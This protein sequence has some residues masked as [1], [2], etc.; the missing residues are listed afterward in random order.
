MDGSAALDSL[1]ADGFTLDMT[2]A[3]PSATT[4]HFMAMGSAATSVSV[5]PAARTAV[6]A[7]VAPTVVHGS[8]A[9]SPSELTAVAASEDPVVVL[10]STPIAPSESTVV[11]AKVDPTVL[12]GSTVA[13]P[14]AGTAVGVVAAPTVLAG[15]ISV[16]PDVIT[17]VAASVAPSVVH[18]SLALSPSSLT[19]VAAQAAPT[20]VLGSTSKTP[21]VVTAVAAS[22]GPTVDTGDII[23]WVDSD[24]ADDSG[25]G[26][27]GDPYKYLD[28]HV[29][30]LGAG[31]TVYIVG[32]EGSPRIYDEG[33]IN[34]TNSNGA[35]GQPITIM[36]APGT[37]VTWQKDAGDDYIFDIH[38]GADYI[39]INGFGLDAEESRGCVRM[40][41]DHG[42]LIYCDLDDASW[43][44]MVAVGG[45]DNE[46]GWCDFLNNYYGDS[47]DAHAISSSGGI[48]EL[49]VHHCTA[50]GI[51]GDF[52]QIGNYEVYHGQDHVIEWNTAWVTL[53]Q[54]ECCEGAVDMKEGNGI[55]RYNTFYNYHGT[56][57]S[58]GGSGSNGEVIFL[59]TTD[60]NHWYVYGNVIYGSTCALWVASGATCDFYWN[61]VYNMNATDANSVRS[62]AVYIGDASTEC[63]VWNNVFHNLGQGSITVDGATA[64]IR[65][66]IFN[67]CGVYTESDTPTVTID[68]NCWYNCTS[69]ESGTG[70]VTS[71]P[72]FADEAGDDYRLSSSS[73]CLLAG[74]DVGLAYSGSAPDMGAYDAAVP[75]AVTAVAA[76]LDP[77]IPIATSARTAVAVSVAPTVVLGSISNTPSA[78]TAVGVSTGPDLDL[79]S[80]TASPSELTA[81]GVSV[82]P[83]VVL[84][85]S[86][87]SPDAV[88]AVAASEDPSIAIGG[89]VTVSPDAVTAVGASTIGSAVQGNLSLTIAARSMIALDYGPA[90]RVNIGPQSITVTPE[91]AIAVAGKKD[92]Y[93]LYNGN[94]ILKIADP[95]SGH[96]AIAVADDI[97]R[98]KWW[99]NETTLCDNWFTVV[100]VINPRTEGGAVDAPYYEYVVN[101]ESG[102]AGYFGEGTAVVNYGQSGAGYVKLTSDDGAAGE[103][104]YID[105]ATHAGSPWSAITTHVRVGQLDGLGVISGS[106]WGLAA[107]TDLS[108]ADEPRVVVSDQQ[109]LLYKVDMTLCEGSITITGG[110]GIA[111]LS[112]A[113]A[114][115]VEDD[116]DGVPDGS[117]YKRVTAN[118]KTG[119]G[120]A[121]SGLDSN[122]NLVTS[123]V[124][125]TNAPV[126]GGAGLYIGADYMGYYD[127]SVWK[128][129]I[130]SNGDFQFRGN[131][132][133]TYIQ[134]DASENKLQGVGSGTEMWYADATDGKLKAGGGSIVLDNVGI[135]LANKA[136]GAS[137][138]LLRWEDNDGDVVA[139]DYGYDDSGSSDYYRGVE[140]RTDLMD[141][142][143]TGIAAFAVRR[144]AAFAFYQIGI[145]S[146]YNT[147][148]DRGI[149]EL[150]NAVDTDTVDDVVKVTNAAGT[151]QWQAD[152]TGD[153]RIAGGLH[154]GSTGTNPPADSITADGYIRASSGV[155][156]GQTG[157]PDTLMLINGTNGGAFYAEGTFTG[158]WVTIGGNSEVDGL[159]MM[160][161]LYVQ[162]VGHVPGTALVTLTMAGA[163]VDV[164][165][166]G[167]EQ[168]SVRVAT[169]GIFQIR[170]RAGTGTAHAIT[171][172][173]VYTT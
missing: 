65:N 115:A 109:V 54:E 94:P 51:R 45:H 151:V 107:G 127:N 79:G 170:Q 35:S 61:V 105:V 63:N 118:E 80:V 158:S 5:S 123:V 33:E 37:E 154:V 161:S 85:G 141:A 106:E 98:M 95:P 163:I 47:T 72:L 146:S 7:S 26:T 86:Q 130:A 144:S 155:A 149:V 92:G 150:R 56:D 108:D 29:N 16:G 20:V 171:V 165:N 24:A 135:R 143:Y 14:S 27:E 87:V 162:G 62:E 142:N 104:P 116:L 145:V 23:V 60:C 91:P 132:A 124:A 25:E 153:V 125:G 64:E 11:A 113:G 117:T 21:A 73:P 131:G 67:D 102:T 57:Q 77:T 93:I 49:W 137:T 114:L 152:M 42:R 4:I 59:H 10:G 44:T 138:A 173:A 36:P 172:W 52:V 81:V 69:S 126:A 50:T 159:T 157:D 139:Y 66:N 6:A 121:Y 84:S 78:L 8:L 40:N 169:G 55:I 160:Y 168:L 1:D 156:V 112:D 111:N 12:L 167:G 41:G 122:N 17:A 166:V 89:S 148:N 28:T 9:L 32:D 46:I 3:D 2:N 83:N 101:R 68:H 128:T 43:W 31:V 140:V 13:A 39:T 74:V 136:G 96:N 88:T 129:Y 76:K 53:G 134:W 71:E 15:S 19:A 75:S 99:A 119:A 58:C 133:T 120:R 22:T 164:Y 34:I 38:V 70:D 90:V 147:S 82:P 18:G 100:E 48:D 97:L 103:I 110:S 30:S